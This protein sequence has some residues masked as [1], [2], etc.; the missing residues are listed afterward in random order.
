[1]FLGQKLQEHGHHAVIVNRRITQGVAR[2]FRLSFVPL[3]YDSNPTRNDCWQPEPSGAI[4][5]NTLKSLYDH[6][7]VTLKHARTAFQD[8]GVDAL[9]VDQ[10]DLASGTVASSLGIPFVSVSF[11]PPIYLN[12][13]IPPFIFGWQPGTA[14]QERRNRRGNVVLENILRPLLRLVNTYRELWRMPELE[15][16]N[17]TFSPLA[18][19]T[20]MPEVFEFPRAIPKH[21]FYTGPFTTAREHQTA[22]FPWHLLDGRPLVYASMGTVRNDSRHTFE[23]IAQACAPLDVQL[24]I[25]LG[26]MLLT[27]ADLPELP[28]NPIVTHYAPQVQILRKA[29]LAVTHGGMNSVLEALS[30]GVPLVAI[31]IADDQPGVAARIQWK[32]VGLAVPIRK[33]D[34]MPLRECIR[35]GLTDQKYRNAAAAMKVHL[36]SIDGPTRTV[37]IIEKVLSTTAT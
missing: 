37:E 7:L 21:L 17:S 3:E 33:L 22:K 13:D 9:L 12:E 19:I 18:I 23:V 27:P 15:G 8:A 1:M 6:S 35:S 34:V 5:P 29:S 11:F 20:Q 30:C 10:A 14:G 4:G 31:P 25:S 24:V 16:I 36:Q 32:S 28:G 2:S 26:G